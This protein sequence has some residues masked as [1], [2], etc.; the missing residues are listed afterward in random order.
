MRKYRIE[1]EQ[2][3]RIRKVSGVFSDRGISI[4]AK[5]KIYKLVINPATIDDLET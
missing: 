2:D 1:F 4:R 3:G 5:G